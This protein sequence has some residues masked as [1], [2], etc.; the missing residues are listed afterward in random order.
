MESPPATQQ[1]HRRGFKC[2]SAVTEVLEKPRV[3]GRGLI[4]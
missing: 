3:D 1:F 2:H 4:S